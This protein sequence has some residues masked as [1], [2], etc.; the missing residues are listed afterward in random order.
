MSLINKSLLFITS[1]MEA[2]IANLRKPNPVHSFHTRRK[3]IDKALKVQRYMDHLNHGNSIQEEFSKGSITSIGDYHDRKVQHSQLRQERKTF[4]SHSRAYATVYSEERRSRSKS[5]YPVSKVLGTDKKIGNGSNLHAASEKSRYNGFTSV[6]RSPVDKSTKKQLLTSM[7]SLT[8][9]Y[10]DSTY[11]IANTPHQSRYTTALK[12]AKRH[13]HDT[14]R[15]TSL[16]KLTAINY[17]GQRDRMKQKQSSRAIRTSFAHLN[18]AK[19]ENK[20]AIQSTIGAGSTDKHTAD[21]TPSPMPV[22]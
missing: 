2:A 4:K 6:V 10:Q 20:K 13:D 9:D 18:I 11:R 15:R 7:K 8:K 3:V 14:H 19:R 5:D 16:T 1:A 12:E 17:V 22:D 21:S